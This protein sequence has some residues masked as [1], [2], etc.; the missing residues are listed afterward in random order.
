M[1]TVVGAGMAGLLAAAM[2]R[3]E[4]GQIL[5]HQPTVPNNHSAVLRFRTSSVGDVLGIPFRQVPVLKAVHPW[6]NP[7]ADAMAYSLKTNGSMAIRSITTA[8][9]EI[10]TRY[11]APSNLISLMRERVSCPVH[12]NANFRPDEKNSQP[13]ISTIPMPNLMD[14]LGWEKTEE[15]QF[16]FGTN[17][18]LDVERLNA[19]ASLYVP[20]PK[21]RGSR[22]SITGSQIVIECQG[23]LSEPAENIA[24][25]ALEYLGI[26]MGLVRKIDSKAQQYAKILPYD[27]RDRRRFILYASERWNIYSLGRFATWRPGLLL[28]DLVNDVRVIH[29]LIHGATNYSQR[30]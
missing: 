18:I 9:G 1:I 10:S 23:K 28:D 7:L 11:I 5:E 24:E 6:R 21:F 26:P 27:E 30:I 2:L 8:T 16:N 17:I 3:T 4:C 20:D 22:I 19:Y 13:I 25:Q 29:R 12:L 15:F 14:L